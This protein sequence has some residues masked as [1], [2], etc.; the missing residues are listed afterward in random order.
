MKVLSYLHQA[1]EST[2]MEWS[3]FVNRNQQT[4]R[5]RHPSI[6]N[7]TEVCY[8]PHNYNVSCKTISKESVHSLLASHRML[9]LLLGFLCFFVQLLCGGEEHW[10]LSLF[11]PTRDSPLKDRSANRTGGQNGGPV[12]CECPSPPPPH[13][14]THA[15]FAWSGVGCSG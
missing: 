2:H 12:H 13:T 3:L 4:Q 5:K 9:W 15:R 6:Y 11:P 10:T 1:A 8:V 14:H 7:I